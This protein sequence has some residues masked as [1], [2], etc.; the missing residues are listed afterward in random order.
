[1]WQKKLLTIFHAQSIIKLKRTFQ[2]KKRTCFVRSIWKVG[3]ETQ[4]F[5]WDP[6]LETPDPSCG[7]DP[8]PKTLKVGAKTRDRGHLFYVGPETQGTGRGIWDTYDRWDPR[9]K[10]SI[11][12]W[13]WGAKTIIQ[14]DLI[15]FPISRVWVII[16]LFFN[17]IIKQLDL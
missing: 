12:S 15:K 4:D 2:N 16:F 3:P 10:T 5:W 11:S 1:M 7:W 9:P 14:M 6:R 17:H 13:A 8:G